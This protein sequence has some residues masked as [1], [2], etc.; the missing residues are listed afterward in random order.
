M[1]VFLRQ[2]TAANVEHA[3][4]ASARIEHVTERSKV[5]GKKTYCCL[6]GAVSRSL[7]Q[8]LFPRWPTDEVPV[9]HV[10][11]GVHVPT[12]DSAYARQVKLHVGMRCAVLAR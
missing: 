12:W 1:I 8:S 2:Q 11:N 3:A 7:F 6:H 10:T 9:R 5:T 4:S